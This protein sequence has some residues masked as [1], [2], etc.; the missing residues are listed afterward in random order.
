VIQLRYTLAAME[1]IEQQIASFDRWHYEFELE[2]HRTPIWDPTWRNRH[3]Q[4]V[5]YFF[6]P[7]VGAAGGSL[8][9]MRVLDLGCNAGF[10]SLQAVN[11]GCDFVLGIDGRSM[12]IEQANLVFAASGVDP[13]RYAFREANLFEIDPGELAGFDI[14]LCLGLLYHVSKPMSLMELIDGT[15]ANAVI[16]DTNVSLVP[17][18]VLEIQHEPI[19]DPRA[20][21][22][23]GLVMIP[24]K[25]AVV[26]LAAQFGF[27]TIVLKPEFSDWEGSADYR[28]R[29]R[30]AFVCTRGEGWSLNELAV[31]PLTRWTR[32]TNTAEW[33]GLAA[34]HT[35]R[36]VGG[37]QLHR[38]RRDR[39]RA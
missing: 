38:Y 15:G 30:R 32:L 2:G 18:S 10:W 21:V 22:D 27:R 7:L 34:W 37:K 13:G 19:S 6:E 5:A 23:Y 17:G 28:L 29:R 26:D 31:E 39:P 14:V 9:G 25:E 33:T 20:A 1:S 36:R 3:A 8:R 16:I 4:R 12:H 35:A 11:A 24:T